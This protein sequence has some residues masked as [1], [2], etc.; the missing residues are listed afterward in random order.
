[1]PSTKKRRKKNCLKCHIP[2]SSKNWASYDQKKGH[3]SC[4]SCRK[5]SDKQCHR[6]DPN[7]SKKQKNRYRARR[8]AV[9]LAYG[10]ACFK[11]GEDDYTKLTI[12]GDINYLYNNIVQKTGYQ[13]TCYN[14]Q[15]IPYTNKYVLKYKRRLIKLYGKHC[16]TCQEDRIERLTIINKQVLCY[17]CY[18][19]KKAAE[20]LKL[21]ELE[22][23]KLKSLQASKY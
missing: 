4:K 9:I 6:N 19:S 2:L 11:C 16:K 5:I 15:K 22:A 7:Y 23:E 12:N 10:N 3:Y 8:S 18:R 1:M 21:E 17:N 13:V 14:C 20:E